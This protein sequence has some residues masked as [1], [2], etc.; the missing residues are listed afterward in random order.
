M[1]SLNSVRVSGVYQRARNTLVFSSRVFLTDFLIFLVLDD[2]GGR[3]RLLGRDRQVIGLGT[4][5]EPFGAG[6]F[7]F[8]ISEFTAEQGEEV[9]IEVLPFPAA[10]QNLMR[11]TVVTSV[12]LNAPSLA[13]EKAMKMSPEPLLPRP[14]TIPIPSGTR[15]AILLS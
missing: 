14:P 2:T 8:T 5:G 3:Y 11:R 10:V 12:R 1:T 15:W 4:V 13:V 9:R 6:G 7:H